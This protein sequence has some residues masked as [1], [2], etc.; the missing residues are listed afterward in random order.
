MKVNKMLIGAVIAAAVAAGGYSAYFVTVN[1]LPQPAEAASRQLAVD[2]SAPMS[3]VLN[4]LENTGVAAGV[5]QKGSS[6]QAAQ[7]LPTIAGNI[8]KNVLGL[9]GIVLVLLIIYAGF[10]WMTAAGNEEKVTKAK[11]ILTGAVIGMVLVMSAYAITAFV[12]SNIVS[13]TLCQN[14]PC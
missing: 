7:Q 14:P 2:N 8:I 1:F 10:L 11:K 5:A 13:S 12:V 9:L 3:G 4:Q 6:A